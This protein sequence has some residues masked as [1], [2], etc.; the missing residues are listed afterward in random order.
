MPLSENQ[1]SHSSQRPS[2]PTAVPHLQV[3]IPDD[4]SRTLKDIRTGVVWHSESGALTESQHVYL[5]NSGV[6]ERLQ[7]GKATRVLEVGFG[8]GLSF[9]LAAT[10]A[11][12]GNALLY[13]LSFENQLLSEPVI[14]ELR[15]RE[16]SE[17]QLAYDQFSNGVFG[18]SQRVSD[19]I[20]CRSDSVEL[21][22]VLSDVHSALW[23]HEGGFDSVFYDPFGPHDAPHMWE[24]VLLQQLFDRLR[25][26][27]RLV[28]YCVKSSIQRLL[29]DVG[30]EV[31]KTR[32]PPGGKREVLVAT[33]R[34]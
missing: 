6:Y 26:R 19:S 34:A 10:A 16:F 12:R 28:T 11:Q 8:T 5:N 13:Y 32:G 21:N 20:M 9:W 22:L 27:G 29:N 14:S 17:C 18:A 4:G 15:H 23:N 30:F 33:R 2:F 25:P 7:R 1:D 31:F 3:V 24:P